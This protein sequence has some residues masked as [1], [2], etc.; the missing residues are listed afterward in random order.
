AGLLPQLDPSLVRPILV[1]AGPEGTE[2]RLLAELRRRVP[3]SPPDSALAEAIALVRDDP[4]ARRP[5][6]LVLVLDQVEQ[7]LQGRPIEPAAELIRAL[8]QCDGRRVQA[9]LLVR[10]DFWMATTR[11]L[12]AVEVPL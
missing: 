9:L 12:R 8:R 1:E 7:W 4:Q 5:E 6:K 10:D 11:L 2:A 3:R